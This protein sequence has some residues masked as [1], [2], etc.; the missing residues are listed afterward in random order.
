MDVS[1]QAAVESAAKE[2]EAAF[3]RLDIL[4]SNARCLERN[5]PIVDSDSDEW[6]KTWI[7]VS[8]NGFRR[9]SPSKHGL[10]Y[11]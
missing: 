8:T 11:E 4:V 2:T 7:V 9:L 5:I 6:W 1:D 3:G 10:T